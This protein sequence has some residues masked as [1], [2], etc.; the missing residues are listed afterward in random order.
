MRSANDIGRFLATALCLLQL[1]G[2]RTDTDIDTMRVVGRD[3]PRE[4]VTK[5]IQGAPFTVPKEEA[6]PSPEEKYAKV[7]AVTIR[8]GSGDA[9]ALL[10]PRIAYGMPPND[11][12]KP[13]MFV[14]RL[15]DQAG[16]IALT[17]TLWDPRWT[18]VW[19]LEGTREHLEVADE[20]ETVLILPYEP[21]LSVL[22]IVKGERVDEPLA[23]IALSEVFD[24]FCTSHLDD[25]D[26]GGN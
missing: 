21:G 15:F 6:E 20:A 11:V 8:V 3:L 5:R 23:A 1:A 17:R 25:P 12:D 14:A 7:L 19:N 22:E 24:A 18:F 4:P 9:V 13:P 26:C 10:D 16:E 2:C